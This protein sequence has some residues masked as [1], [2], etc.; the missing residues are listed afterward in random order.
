MVSS[1]TQSGIDRMVRLQVEPPPRSIVNTTQD[2][3]ALVILGFGIVVL[4][5]RYGRKN[6]AN[7]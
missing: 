5:V 2:K 6:N 1:I 7:N 4:F 3:I